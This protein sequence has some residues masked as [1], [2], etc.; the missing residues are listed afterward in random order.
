MILRLRDNNLVPYPGVRL[1]AVASGAGAVAGSNL[2]T[3]ARGWV[4]INWKLDSNPGVNTLTLRHPDEPEVSVT[5]RAV[6]LAT[7]ARHRD[8]RTPPDPVP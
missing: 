5:L 3:D 1:E 8:P 4:R 2:V 6:G 7:P